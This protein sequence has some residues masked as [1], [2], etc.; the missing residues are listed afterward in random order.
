MHTRQFVD[1]AVDGADVGLAATNKYFLLKT[2]DSFKRRINAD[3]LVWQSWD[4]FK[5]LSKHAQTRLLS[6]LRHRLEN[7]HYSL[8]DPD[9]SVDG[10]NSSDTVNGENMISESVLFQMIMGQDF[11]GQADNGN[12]QEQI[13]KLKREYD[14]DE[15]AFHEIERWPTEVRAGRFN[16][17]AN[18]QATFKKLNEEISKQM[19]RG[20][21]VLAIKSVVDK[22]VGWEASGGEA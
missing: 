12:I 11:R 3:A 20:H 5:P 15:E 19:T 1:T 6:I 14:E 13:N 21:N 7:R 18:N 22:L 4:P 16:T 8:A 9:V 17:A 2:I 10:Y